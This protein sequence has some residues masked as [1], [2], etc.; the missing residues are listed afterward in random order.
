MVLC[1]RSKLD[2]D[3]QRLARLPCLSIRKTKHTTSCSGYVSATDF[4][5][6]PDR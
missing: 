5:K 1:I 6:K 2:T 4:L 3:D